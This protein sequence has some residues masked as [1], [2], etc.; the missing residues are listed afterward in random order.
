MLLFRKRDP[1]SHKKVGRDG[2]YSVLMRDP[3]NYD[4]IW[5][6]P[7]D[8]GEDWKLRPLQTSGNIEPLH[9]DLVPMLDSTILKDIKILKELGLGS[10]GSVYEIKGFAFLGNQT[11]VSNRSD[12]YPVLRWRRFAMKVI[13]LTGDS[14]LEIKVTLKDMHK[15]R[16][17]RHE[18]IYNM[19]DIIGIPHRTTGFPYAVVCFVMKLGDGDFSL[20]T[21]FKLDKV[22]PE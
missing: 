10:F 18:N 8:V 15:L 12:R 5:D 1:F 22:N 11:F 21:I 4:W 14:S 16:Y 7:D 19:F 2:H 17:L 9:E 6:I 20:G 3:K 13:Q